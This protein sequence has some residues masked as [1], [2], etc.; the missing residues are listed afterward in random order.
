MH[1]YLRVN[2]ELV[3]KIFI[4]ILLTVTCPFALITSKDLCVKKADLIFFLFAAA[5]TYTFVACEM[6]TIC[7]ICI[8]SVVFI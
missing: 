1:H 5:N 7:I 6:H 3:I 4:R 8:F 2:T